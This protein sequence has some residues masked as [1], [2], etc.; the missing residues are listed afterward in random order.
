MVNEKL[1]LQKLNKIGIALT[2]ERDI[3]KLL[4]LILKESISITNCDA[5]S[6]Y[7]KE[8]NEFGTPVI[9]FKNAIN[10]S[11]EVKF[12]EFTLNLDKKS[13]AGYVAMTGEVLVLN[14]VENIDEKLELHYNDAFDKMINYKSV[15]MLVVPMISYNNEVVGVLQLINKKK[16]EVLLLNNPDIISSQ[17]ESFVKEEI[18]II[19]SLTAQAGILIERTHLYDEIQ[20]LLSS[21]IQAMVVTL[22][23][24]DI[25]TSGHSRRLAGYALGFV[26]AINHVN[27]GEFKNLIFTKEQIKEIYYA[28]LLHD[29]GKI[30]VSETVLQKRTKVALETI[31]LFEYKL[32]YLKEKVMDKINK[33]SDEIKFLDKYDNYLKIIK[34][35]NDKPFLTDEEEELLNELNSFEFNFNEKNIRMFKPIEFENLIIKRGNLTNKEREEINSHVSYSYNI[36]K[37]IKWTKELKDVPNIASSHHEKID[38]TGYPRKLKGEE[39]SVQARILAMLDIFEALT[40]R[41]R[42]Y[43]PPMAVEKAIEILKKE[44][45]DNHLDKNLFEIFLKEKIYELYKEELNKI[46]NL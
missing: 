34:M 8:I 6:I 5:G 42:P 38:G 23:A 14:D 33:N 3:G 18:E 28:A 37:D 29:I 17:V 41:D 22:D 16:H 27:Y 25:T 31:E 12:N 45:E 21:F 10:L 35:V 11:R 39:I 43:K 7:I 1:L 15:N 46:V 30:G 13:I 4:E 44:V 20:E 24:R 2:S 32:E 26:E 36:L 19:E 40:A 9:R